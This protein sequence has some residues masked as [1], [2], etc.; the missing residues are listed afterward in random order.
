[1]VEQP[2]HLR[3]QHYV[4]AINIFKEPVHTMYTPP[5]RP[6]PP[7]VPPPYRPHPHPPTQV[8]TLLLK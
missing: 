7:S 6:L 4:R 8:L 1:M 2:P 3:Q 5:L